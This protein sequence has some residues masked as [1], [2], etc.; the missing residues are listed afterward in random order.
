[1]PVAE[2]SARPKNCPCASGRDYIRCCGPLH[3]GSVVAPSAEALMR[4]R[5][6]AFVLGL[7]DYLLASWHP[8]TRP[9]RLELSTP[10]QPPLRW[11]GLRILAHAVADDGLRAEVEF[12]ARHKQGGGPAGRLHER[13][14]FVREDGRWFYLDGELQS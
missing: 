14:R 1:M 6:S 2:T 7:V 3:A 4:S 10:G 9:V 5:Y 8:S 13:S 12:I 11:L